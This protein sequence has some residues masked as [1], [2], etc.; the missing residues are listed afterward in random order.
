MLYSV[1][2]QSPDLVFPVADVKE[3]HFFSTGVPIN[4]G[5]D[6]VQR[7]GTLK[8]YEDFWGSVDPTDSRTYVDMTSDYFR[9]GA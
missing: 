6:L 3:T 5:K 4:A 9:V 1:L 8:E 2:K 7:N